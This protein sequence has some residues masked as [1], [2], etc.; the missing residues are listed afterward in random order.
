MGIAE[1][2]PIC[3]HEE[4]NSLDK[5]LVLENQ[6][7]LFQRWTRQVIPADAE[8]MII[9]LDNNAT[10]RM[11]PEVLAAMLPFLQ[12]SYGNAGS[13]HVLGLLSEGALVQSR[14]QVA[15]MLG[16]S[17]A[18]VLFNSGGTE[19]INHTFRGVFEAFPNQ[20]HFIISA[21]EHPAV[22]AVCEWLKSQGAEVTSLGVDRD[23]QLDLAALAASIRPDTALVSLMAANNESGVLFPL[24]KVVQLV[25]GKGALLHVDAT[26]SIGKA[27]LDLATLPID[28]LN[29]SGHKFH[30]PK[31]TGALFIRRGLRLK[32]FMLGGHQERG[33]RGGTENVP[34]IVGLGKAS[35][36]VLA[37]L[38]Q[39]A[40][41]GGLRDHF[42][43]AIR[44]SIKGVH[45]HGAGAPRLPNTSFMGF[46]GLE[47]EALL[48]KLSERG[49]CVSTGS[50]C[51]TG[52]KEPS[53]VLR[54]MSA[55]KE[56]ALGTIRISLCRYTTR[57][58]I[59]TVLEMLPG[60][61]EDLRGSNPFTRA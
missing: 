25:K 36:M 55:P 35:E 58:E 3:S 15:A 22:L 13:A 4:R 51:T 26:Q 31:G 5:I 45:L 29:V 28:L 52:Q 10:T 1:Q 17:P 37:H 61:V 46:Q 9:Y 33:R 11:A 47:G 49:V 14:E 21:V 53:H 27:P 19:G 16:C 30:G 2:P 6:S 50:A 54:A 41:M 34:G 57:D 20:R 23:G 12:E 18:E 43:S 32:P 40:A 39:V 7:I 44:D 8:D 42:E 60:I 56:F 24:D 59:Q 38:P 48:M